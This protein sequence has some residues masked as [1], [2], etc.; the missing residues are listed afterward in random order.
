ML[1]TKSAFRLCLLLALCLSTFAFARAQTATATLSGTVTDERGAI[2]PGASITVT[3]PATGL[4]RRATT[5]DNGSFTI[6]LLP[7]STYTVL[8][9]RQGFAPAKI[10]DV[11]LNVTEQ[12]S[13]Q[14]QLKVGNIG[15]TVTVQAT[16][17]VQTESAA[18]STVVNRQFVENLPL[19]GRS[20]Q[21]L[22]SLTP[23]VVVTKTQPGGEE[24]QFSVNG[25]R[26]NANYFMVDGAGASAGISGGGQLGQSGTGALPGLAIT[27]GTNNLVSVDALQEFQVQTSSYAAE[28]GRSPGAQISIVTRSGTNDFRGTLFEYFRNEA[29]DANDY[30]ANSRG[31]PKAP[32]RQNDF[33]FVVGGPVFFPR[34]G[35]GGKSIYNGHDRTFFFFSYEGLRLRLPQVK[36]TSVPSLSARQT[37]PPQIQPFLN[38]F[39]IPNGRVLGNG[40]AEFNASYSNPSTLNATSIRLDHTI[41][42]KLSLFGR[43]NYAP[44]SGSERG[45]FYGSLNTIADT[46]LRTETLTIGATSIFTSSISNDFHFNYSR[47]KGASIF[48]LD[49]LGGAMPPPDSILFPPFASSNDSAFT[50]FFGSIGFTVGRISDNKQHQINLLDNLSVVKASH[51][52][53]F[54]VDYRLLTPSYAPYK[55]YNEVFVDPVTGL[56]QFAYISA[57]DSA[58]LSF[59]NFSAYGQDTW[60]AS[61]RLTLTYGLRW[62]FNPP[63]K[64]RNGTSLYTVQGLDNLATLSLAPVGTPLYKTGYTNFAPRIGAAYQLSQKSGRETVLR[65]GFGVFYD[66]QAGL[67]GNAPTAFPYA[68]YKL[69]FDGP[70]PIDPATA[71]PPAF[72]LN[73]PVGRIYVSDPN[74]EAPR[75]YQ[76]NLAVEQSLGSKQTITAS[77]VAAAGRRLLRQEQLL[78]PNPNFQIV[79]IQRSRG[80]SDYRALQI[81]F[82]RRLSRGLQALASYTFSKS[83]DDA[84]SETT[85]FAPGDKIDPKIDRGPSD[86]DVRHSF[87]AAV[88]YNIPA[89][90]FGAIGKAVLGGWATDIIYKARTATPVDVYTGREFFGSYTASRPDLVPGVPLYINDPSVA[91]GRR[92]NSA[93]FIVPPAIGTPTVRRQGT[94]GRNALRGFPVRQ[95][96]IALR[97]QFNFTERYNLQLRAELFNA[98]NHPNFADP[99]GN[100][101]SGFFGQST[102]MLGRSLG[103]LNSLYQIGG[104]RSVQ[105][106]LK[107]QF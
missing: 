96:D 48:R 70:F 40:L 25:Q 69:L 98:F 28:F 58:S 61:R 52:L 30:F 22:I 66:L 5:S 74:L 62:E 68:R 46:N 27:G 23:G 44:S 100:L 13:L 11:V 8:V 33:G 34:F 99:E 49:N 2:V 76:W 104:P 88:T 67:T 43:Y 77:Y 39:P 15:E 12:R 55:S 73:P 42:K 35:E 79:D 91:G 9:E 83:T 107:L 51:V 101:R 64:G 78:N 54:G 72:T 82:D 56:I 105:L 10:A 103:G 65:G 75:T 90:K 18:V 89:P 93:A 57:S 24:G 31:L 92:I 47:Y 102:Q 81:Q 17:G 95:L 84:S 106:A 85:L 97:R 60:K 37:A 4:Q 59:T 94:L 63:P 3:N 16:S 19:N 20:F 50:V 26:P 45:A 21:S 86:F 71:V 80:I 53:K 87:A 7:P 1:S 6:P 41:N 29:L 32:L 14:I 38:A 36:L